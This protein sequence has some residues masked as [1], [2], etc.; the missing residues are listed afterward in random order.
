M[1]VHFRGYAHFFAQHATIFGSRPSPSCERHD[2]EDKARFI[3]YSIPELSRARAHGKG[4]WMIQEYAVRQWL[5]HEKSVWRCLLFQI[6]F[7]HNTEY[8]KTCGH[9]TAE[10]TEQL[11]RS[12]GDSAVLAKTHHTDAE[13]EN[14][15]KTHPEERKTDTPPSIY[16]TWPA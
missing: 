9:T 6:P 7:Y 14:T 11:Q 10:N 13:E 3:S 5:R 12:T 8:I 1:C 16:G 2:H 15:D 4:R